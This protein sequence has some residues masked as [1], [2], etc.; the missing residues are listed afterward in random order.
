MDPADRFPQA[1]PQLADLIGTGKLDVPVWRAYPLAAA[2]QAHADIE[3]R[4]NRGKIVL[5]P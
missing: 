4:R 5:L 2:D 1:L 3:A